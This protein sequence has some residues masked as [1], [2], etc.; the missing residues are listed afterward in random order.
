MYDPYIVCRRS[1]RVRTVL[2]PYGGRERTKSR[3][4]DFGRF[5]PTLV[6]NAQDTHKYQFHAYP[7][8]FSISMHPV[9][10]F[11]R[12]AID[13]QCLLTIP[14]ARKDEIAHFRFWPV[15]TDHGSRA[16]LKACLPLLHRTH[17]H[18]SAPYPGQ[19]SFQTLPAAQLRSVTLSVEG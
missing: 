1:A 12:L 16:C 4:F 9:S 10:R 14:R 2:E 11:K 5:A 13:S 17:M 7:N 6:L 3:I 19:S 15:N 18:K 8:C